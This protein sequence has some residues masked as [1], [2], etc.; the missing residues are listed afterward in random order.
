MGY[1]IVSF[2]VECLPN[3][4]RLKR[5]PFVVEQSETE[6]KHLRMCLEDV[7]LRIDGIVCNETV[8][9]GDNY[10]D[11]IIAKQMEQVEEEDEDDEQQPISSDHPKRSSSS[12]DF[13]VTPFQL[14]NWVNFDDFKTFEDTNSKR[15]KEP[16]LSESSTSDT[17]GTTGTDSS[18]DISSSSS[19]SK[20]PDRR[21]SKSKKH[22]IDYDD[23]DS[24]IRGDNGFKNHYPPHWD[25]E[26]LKSYSSQPLTLLRKSASIDFLKKVACEPVLFESDSDAD[27]SW[28]NGDSKSKPCQSSS[29]GEAPTSDPARLAFRTIMD[30]LPLQCQSPPPPP[31]PPLPQSAKYGKAVPKSIKSPINSPK[32]FTISNVKLPLK[33]IFKG[34]CQMPSESSIHNE[35]PPEA[36]D[37][38]TASP[39][40]FTFPDVIDTLPLKCMVKENDQTLSESS[41]DIQ[42]ESP[43]TVLSH[44]LVCSMFPDIMEDL[45]Q[46]SLLNWNC[47]SRSES[48]TFSDVD[49]DILDQVVEDEIQAYL[50][51]TDNQNSGK[52]VQPS[53][54]TDRRI[55]EPEQKETRQQQQC[56]ESPPGKAEKEEVG[57]EEFR[58]RKLDQKLDEQ[59]Q[60][61]EQQCSSTTVQSAVPTFKSSDS[62]KRASKKKRSVSFDEAS[63]ST[64]STASTSMGN[65]TTTPSSQTFVSLRGATSIGSQTSAFS[66]YSRSKTKQ[67]YE[68]KIVTQDQPFDEVQEDWINFQSGSGFFS[69]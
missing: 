9:D 27:D 18:D 16:K 35:P 49:D 21:R 10:L 7:A 15:K 69:R 29:S 25:D 36:T 57:T 8:D 67:Q 43:S 1:R 44:D 12:S 23:F 46:E 41:V 30:H 34:N 3:H 6:L 33:P 54:Q 14:Q 5:S 61:I 60:E 32:R 59:Q 64:A 65:S 24:I 19:Q 39:T 20:S 37:A 55:A 51:E 26:S 56:R 2:L 4:P 62:A 40:R 45:P 48:P 22:D 53:V 38:P 28:A 58:R 13:E 50:E 52:E 68:Y 47:Q 31:P 63:I 66:V 11:M 17:V 42:S